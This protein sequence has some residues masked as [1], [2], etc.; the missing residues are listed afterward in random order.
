MVAVRQ[1]PRR[2]GTFV[3]DEETTGFALFVAMVDRLGFSGLVAL[4]LLAQ[5]TALAVRAWLREFCGAGPGHRPEP[6]RPAYYDRRRSPCKGTSSLPRTLRN[7][8]PPGG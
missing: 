2:P 4:L 7:G 1:Q 5:A 3:R 8:Y 6:F